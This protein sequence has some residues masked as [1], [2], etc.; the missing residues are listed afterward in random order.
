MGNFAVPAIPPNA[1]TLPMSGPPPARFSENL[2]ENRALTPD[3][4][5]F[6]RTVERVVRELGFWDWRYLVDHAVVTTDDSAYRRSY[7]ENPTRSNWLLCEKVYALW[8]KN[9][10][11]K[12]EFE[13]YLRRVQKP[14]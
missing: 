6:I 3:G 1:P 11:A 12:P 7:F 8:K 2:K 10:L 4:P 13:Q 14:Q 5:Q 9:L